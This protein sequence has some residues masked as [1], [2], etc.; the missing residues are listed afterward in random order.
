MAEGGRPNLHVNAVIWIGDVFQKRFGLSAMR[1]DCGQQHLFV[2]QSDGALSLQRRA[3]V[4]V[5]EADVWLR[6]GAEG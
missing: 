3:A 5:G 2:G 4:T 6:N 1:L